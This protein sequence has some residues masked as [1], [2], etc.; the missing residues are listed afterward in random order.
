MRVSCGELVWI[1]TDSILRTELFRDIEQSLIELLAALR[2]YILPARLLCKSLQDAS[3]L[4]RTQIL[5]RIR[6][7]NIYSVDRRADLE[8]KREHLLVIM[9]A[10]RICSV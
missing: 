8:R 3:R 1:E 10:S 2:F 6:I 7:R 4:K 9:A 5:A